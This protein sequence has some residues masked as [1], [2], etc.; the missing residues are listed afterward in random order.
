VKL[1]T[2]G[3]AEGPKCGLLFIYFI[4]FIYFFFVVLGT[5]SL[6]LARQAR[7]QLEPLL[8]PFFVMGFFEIGSHELFAWGW[9]LTAILLWSLSP[10]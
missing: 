4:L 2:P 6:R 3:P 9:L 10:E 5:Q 7:L 1:S 8:Q